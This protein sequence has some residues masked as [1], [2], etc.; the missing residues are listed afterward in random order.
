LESL[1]LIR[2]Y[3]SRDWEDVWN[4]LEPVF[5]EGEC[6]AF[7]RDISP[8]RARQIW[9]DT[10]EAFVA[11]DDDGRIIGTYYLRPNFEGGGSHVCNCGYAVSESARGRG[12]AA[13]MCELSQQ[14]AAARGYLAMQFNFVVSSNAAAVNLWKKMGFEVVGTLPR[15]FRHPKLG[16]VDAF[17]M[18]KF[19]TPAK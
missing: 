8:E 1:V 3:E 12:V 19:L 14:E 16:L 2:P 6:Y 13:A 15:V 11:V 7:P 10:K 4:V 9:T 5:R 18:H 17:V